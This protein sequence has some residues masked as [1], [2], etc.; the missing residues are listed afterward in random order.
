MT[1]GATLRRLLGLISERSG[2]GL[3]PELLEGARAALLAQ[4]VDLYLV[5]RARQVLELRCR[6]WSTA[7]PAE[8]PPATPLLS[9]SAAHRRTVQT[10]P[11]ALA[12]PL[13]SGGELL[14][15]LHATLAEPR[16]VSADQLEEAKALAAVTAAAVSAAQGHEQ[17][18]R[19]RSQIDIVIRAGMAVSELLA[20]L[21]EPHLR[22]AVQRGFHLWPYA[23]EETIPGYLASL[24]DEMVEHARLAVGAQFAALGIGD[25]PV[26][27]FSPWVFSGMSPEVAKSIGRHPRPVGTLGEVAREAKTVRVPD[28]RRH[29]RYAGL[30]P[31]HPEV[32]SFLGVPIRYRGLV[33]GNLYLGNK[34]GAAEFSAEDQRMA[35]ML[36]AH[37]GLVFQQAYLRA[38][39]DAE[40][41]QLQIVLDSAPH[42]I[43]FIEAA[44]GHVMANPRAMQ[45]FGHTLVPEGGRE[46]YLG[47]VR[48]PSGETVALEELPGSRALAG[49]ETRDAQYTIV[50]PGGR[51]IPVLLS[52]SPVRGLG[53]EVIGAVVIFEDISALKQ[54]QALREQFASLVAHDLR[55][56]IQTI[57]I[58][59]RLLMRDQGDPAQVPRAALR[60]MTESALRLQRLTGDLLDAHEMELGRLALEPRA[61]SL[62]AAA[63]AVI[64]RVGPSLGQHPVEFSSEAEVPPVLLDPS[65]LD[66][67]LTNLLENAARYSPSGALIRVSVSARDGG[68]LL[69]VE[70]HGVGIAPQDAPRVFE[71][72]FRLPRSD[73]DIP[74]SLGLGLFITRG[75]VEAHGGRIWLESEPGKGSTFYIWLPPGKAGEPVP[76]DT[77]H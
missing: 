37:A 56:P 10:E 50:Q 69:S 23:R 4:G 42:G 36:A 77:L 16:V 73:K 33:L 17:E 24:L 58:Q 15:V 27:P 59:A 19:L 75:L 14:G 11:A 3:L 2:E 9:A 70:D 48:S 65:R 29:E 63:L 20:I 6:V 72:G 51:R 67:M 57:L 30:P 43:L 53:N 41:A 54:L 26:R 76:A 22:V 46:Q 60:R 35:E 31:G 12:L 1:A 64:D 18:S 74:R 25:D 45:I 34:I 32:T 40:R 71:R 38:A 62:E 66:Q 5:D 61:S 28:V 68:A 21:P 52:A 49:A 39:I 55:N 47:Q 8:E 44:S 7:P 13:F